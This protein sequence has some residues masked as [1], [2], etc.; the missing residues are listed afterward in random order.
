MGRRGTDSRGMR[1]D[2]GEGQTAVG[3]EDRPVGEETDR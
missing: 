1:G 3:G 2:G